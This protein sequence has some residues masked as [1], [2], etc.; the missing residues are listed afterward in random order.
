MRDWGAGVF[1]GCTQINKLDIRIFQR[2][3]PVLKKYFQNMRQMLVVDY[4]DKE[5]K[6]LAK[7]IFPEFLRSP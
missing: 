5:G 7:L 1:T 2:K 4:R 3:N 6:L